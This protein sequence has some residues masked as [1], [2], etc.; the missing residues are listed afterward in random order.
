[1]LYS[2]FTQTC[3]DIF[4]S[5]WALNC[6]LSSCLLGECTCTVMK[7]PLQ[8]AVSAPTEDPHQLRICLSLHICRLY[9]ARVIVIR[10]LC[11]YG[12]Q[13]QQSLQVC[14]QKLSL[15]Q[16]LTH[17]SVLPY[18]KAALLHARLTDEP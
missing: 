4:Y 16:S 5:F 12:L 14:P 3:A 8:T 15:R 10:H 11:T 2:A 17:A 18:V 7:L 13:T 1:M 9:E 6:T